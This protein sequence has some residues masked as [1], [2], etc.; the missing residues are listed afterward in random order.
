MVAVVLE[1]FSYFLEYLFSKCFRSR[2]TERIKTK[3]EAQ[4]WRI[5][6]A[7]VFI[8]A[9][10]FVKPFSIDKF[11]YFMWMLLTAEGAIA[12]G[13]VPRLSCLSSWGWGVEVFLSLGGS[14][15]MLGWQIFDSE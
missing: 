4:K 7:I 3:I 5:L 11:C 10:N 13:K 15:E 6:A 1:K 12:L 8:S 14:G 2:S 9:Y